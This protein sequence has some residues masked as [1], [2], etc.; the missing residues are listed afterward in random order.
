MPLPR[1][2]P[3]TT[4]W[5]VIG[6][7]GI[8]AAVAVIVWF[9]L[10]SANSLRAVVTAYN[11]VSDSEVTVSY[12]VHRPDGAAVQCTVDAQDVR[13]GRVGTITD[14]VPAGATSVHRVVTVRTSARAVVGIVSSCVRIP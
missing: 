11:V 8:S 5:W 4:K 2:A 12:D 10:A 7:V 14:D 13:H 6:A 3:G 1:P 9:A